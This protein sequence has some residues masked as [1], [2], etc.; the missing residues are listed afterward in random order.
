MISKTCGVL[1]LAFLVVLLCAC[2]RKVAESDVPGTYAADYGFAKETLN[3]TADRKFDQEI[4]L[5]SS[6]RTAVAHGTWRFD[7][8]DSDIYFSADFLIVADGF[9]KLIADFDQPSRK[10]TSILPVRARF[11]KIQIGLDPAVPY[12]KLK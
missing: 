3:V 11:G 7:Q 2:S 6:G 4:K 9:G 8:D 12:K 5:T 1:S 10:L